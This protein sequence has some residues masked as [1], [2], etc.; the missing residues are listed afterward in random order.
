M[1]NYTMPLREYIEMWSQN[2]SLSTRDKIEKGRTKLFDFDYPIFDVSYKKVFETHFIRNFFTREI[3]FETEGLFKFHLETW[4]MVNMPYFNKLFE[5]EL[6]AFDPLTNTK[7]DTTIKKTND[8]TQSNTSK[9]D[10]TSNTTNDATN[11]TTG[12]TTTS[13]T[14]NQTANG[15]QTGSDFNRQLESNTP[16]SRLTITTN[17]GAGVIE[18]A[19]KIQE[20]SDKKT[21][22]TEET[23]EVTHDGTVDKTSTATTHATG[24]DVTS[25][26]STG[27]GTINEIED[28]LQSKTG[29]IGSQ[30]YS[31]MVNEYRE[32]FLRIEK[33]MFREMQE[34]FMLVY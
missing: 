29:K 28:Y 14:E 10:G 17:D 31:S 20:N 13:N 26:T 7:Q 9:T 19:S 11:S 2:E 15:S 18:Y 25:V 1:S 24:E 12:N 16:D 6:I 8:K 32:S 22:T 3:G 27:N 30:T 33:Q 4:L 34:L 5:S 21:N 23:N